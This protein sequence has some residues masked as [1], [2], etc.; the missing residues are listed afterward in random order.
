MN[1]PGF[2]KKAEF[3]DDSFKTQRSYS[4][5]SCGLCDDITAPKIK[6]YGK[7]GKFILIIGD[8]PLESSKAKGNPWKGQPGRLLENTLNSMGIDLYKD[9]LSI[10][11][12]NCCPPQDR[13]PDNNEVICCR[14]VHVFKTIEKYNPHIIL[15]LGPSAL[16]SF[17][18]HRWKRKLGGI[19]KWRG[20]NIP[21]ADYKAWVCPTFHPAY[22]IS[23]DRKEVR[24]IW[25]NDLAKA[26]KKVKEKLP[27]FK[28]PIINYITDLS[29]LNDIKKGMSAFDYETSG[30][31]PHLQ[32]QKIVCAS[33]APDANNVYVFPMPKRKK[34]R[35][36]FVN[37]LKNINVDKIASNLKFEDNWSKVK[38]HTEV[39]S[40]VWDT[41]LAAN[42][43][44]NSSG[45][46]SLNLQTYVRLGVV[47]Y[48]SDVSYFLKSEDEKNGNSVNRIN[49]LIAKPDGLK[50]L[51]YYCALDSIYEFR[52]A[53][54][55]MKEMNYK[56]D[57]LPF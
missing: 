22:V 55:Q 49:E 6:P 18:G 16:F 35:V 34:E 39:K 28:A 4:C 41:M 33:V 27:R 37:Y 40:W 3:K 13:L 31:K 52:I 44:D 25:R 12:V 10:N 43:L 48:D 24:V 26:L 54:L 8:A 21:D 30:L 51:L 53:E 11:A 45:I 5:F 56:Y 36:P 32:I 19:D 38:L 15:L 47:D 29:P 9:C 7:F 1:M 2:F 14:N 17:L 50:K 23:Q 42:K 46:T 20:W 57:P